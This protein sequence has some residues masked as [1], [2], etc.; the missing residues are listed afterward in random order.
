MPKLVEGYADRLHVPPGV[1]DVQV[2]DDDL[3]GFGLRKFRSGRAVYFV[4]YSIGHQQRRL[5]LGVVVRGN[6][7]EMRKRASTVLARAR[8]GEDAVAEKRAAAAKRTAALGVLVPKYLAERQPV[9]RPRYFAEIKRQLERDWKPLHGS[10]VDAISRA[11]VI[12]VVDDVAARQGNVAADRARVALSGLFAWAIGRNYAEA[13][14]T[15]NIG[16]RAQAIARDRVLSEAE[17]VEVWRACGD[18]DYGRIVRLL[19]LTGQRR[20]EIGGL[21]WAE[22]DRDK[23]RLDLPGSRTKNGRAHVVP[24]GD[25]AMAILEAVERREDREHVF[26]R[27]AGGFS[28]WSKAK[29]ELDARIAA[30]RKAA[31]LKKAMPA[32]RLHDLR[33]SFVTH[34]NERKIAPP[35]VVEAI[36]NHVSGHLAGVAGTYNKAVYLDERR[37]ALQAWGKH[38]AEIVERARRHDGVH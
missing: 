24:L 19:M 14:P 11:D 4:K 20:E 3:P 37:E 17:L 12:R 34:V 26:G 36:V 30:A 6:C 7:T 16:P 8:L 18:D 9:L 38:V 33:R 21:V 15:L 5:T 31:G 27:G 29:A 2:F 35:H 28:G 1:R 10:A 32:W 13:N 22:I 23:R 25:Q